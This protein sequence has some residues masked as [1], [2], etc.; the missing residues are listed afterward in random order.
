MSGIVSTGNGRFIRAEASDDWSIALTQFMSL[1]DDK[2]WPRR[3][4][5][6]VA[7][8]E[9]SPYG[10]KIVT[11]YHWLEIELWAL[12][13]VVA[14]TGAL[15]P[16]PVALRAAA[17]LIFASTVVDLHGNLSAAGQRVLK[18]RL[19][20]GVNKGLAGLFLE[21]DLASMLLDAG[22]EVGFP[23]FEGRANYDLDVMCSGT[24]LAVECKSVSVDAG[25]KIRRADFYRFMSIIERDLANR[26]GGQADITVVT[27]TDR[28]PAHLEQQRGVA[29]TVFEAIDGPIGRV[30]RHTSY[31]VYRESISHL[32]ADMKDRNIDMARA[33]R[34]R[35]GENC[36]VAGALSDN[37][38]HLIV[39]RSERE[40]DPSHV[41]L[42]ARKA[43]A[44]QLPSDRPGIV[45][46]QYDDIT[47]QD[48]SKPDFR[49]RATILDNAVLHDDRANH[50]AAIYHCAFD[51]LW[52]NQGQPAKP[53]FVSWSTNWYSRL[54]DTPFTSGVSNSRFAELL[55]SAEHDP[56]DHE[57]G[58]G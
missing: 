17:A 48:L 5:Q 9:R 33:L 58:Y 46:L 27:I 12:N 52:Q 51:G 24:A 47:V 13:A 22:C 31:N 38:G 32:I 53:A 3:A 20:D 4:R 39:I 50:V 18:G 6:L 40:D 36:H 14:E 2:R 42:D 45:A 55:G 26:S 49:R 28:F 10:A 1:L 35:F 15:P 29:Q 57:Y 7:D 25:R 37:S 34:E 11:D 56:D 30:L 43:A 41:S 44:K 23:D 21:L 8:A 16:P 54:P 19:L